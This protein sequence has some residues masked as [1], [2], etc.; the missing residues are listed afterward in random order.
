M[1]PLSTPPPSPLTYPLG[2]QTNLLVYAVIVAMTS[3]FQFKTVH[4][5]HILQVPY[6]GIRL[7]NSTRLLRAV[8]IYDPSVFACAFLPGADFQVRRTIINIAPVMSRARAKT[9]TFKH[10]GLECHFNSKAIASATDHTY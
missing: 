7:V 2:R 5:H 3:S 10:I 6:I 1:E 4:T 8:A 9:W